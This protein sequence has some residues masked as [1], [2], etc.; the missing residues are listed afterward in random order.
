[1]YLLGGGAGEMTLLQR[2]FLQAGVSALAYA[3]FLI[4]P[5]SLPLSPPTPP[6]VSRYCSDSPPLPRVKNSYLRC[7]PFISSHML[8][9]FSSST[10]TVPPLTLP[11]MTQS[12]ITLGGGGGGSELRNSLHMIQ[13]LSDEA[14]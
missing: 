12:W 9:T 3:R 5:D 13:S 14:N 6:Y 8:T 10:W 1:M 4:L 11:N 7:T 2:E